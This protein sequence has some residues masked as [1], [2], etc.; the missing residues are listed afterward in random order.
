MKENDSNLVAVK[1]ELNLDVVV[2]KENRK[3]CM[4]FFLCRKLDSPLLLL[5]LLRLYYEGER[6]RGK[7]GIKCEE[8]SSKEGE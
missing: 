4:H 5:F 7:Q 6:L 8:C 2:K 1:K 3:W